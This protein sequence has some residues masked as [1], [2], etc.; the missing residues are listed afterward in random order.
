MRR[1]L[2]ALGAL[3]V[4]AAG[5]KVVKAGTDAGVANAVGADASSATAAAG[6]A[7]DAG[8]RIAGD[9]AVDASAAATDA[10]AAPAVVPLP[11]PLPLPLPTASVP[12]AKLVGRVFARGSRKPV[13]DASISIDLGA[14]GEAES[15]HDGRFAFDVPCGRHQLRVQAPGFQPLAVERDACVDRA[16]LLVR[17]APQANASNYETLVR[18]Q[19]VHQD[20]S[21][22][23]D[24]LIHTAGTLGDPFRVIETLPGVTSV[25]WPAPIYAVRGSNPGNTGFFL[26][27]LRVPALFHFALGPSVINPY[28]FRDLDFFAGG[29]PA[30]YGRYVAGIVAARTRAAPDDDLH[31]SVDLRLYDAGAIV[32]APLPGQGSIA[33]AAR[34]SYTGTVI[35]YLSDAA[36]NLAYWDYQLRA[37]RSFG[38]VRLTLLAFGSS[39]SL[40]TRSDRVALRFH[41]V[42]LRAERALGRG[43]IAA[44]VG[45]GQDHSEAPIVNTVPITISAL[46]V[47]PRAAYTLPSQ[48]ADLELGFDGEIEHFDSV[49]MLD[50]LNALDLARRRTARL[51]AGYA[52]VVVRAGP[53]LVVTPELRLDSYAVSGVEKADLGPRLAARLAIDT[54]TWV[55]LSGGRF[56]QLPS[57]PLQVPGAE[58]F[59]LALYGLQS[60]WQG[61]LALGTTRFAG[62]DAS[63][64][65]Y[66]QRYVLTDVRDSVLSASVDPL[67]DDF[68]VQRDALSYGVELFIRRPPTERLHGWLSYTLSNNER[69]LGGGVIGPS[70]WDQ[71]QVVNLVLGYR[72]RSYTFGGRAH[73]NTGRP[74][75]VKGAGGEVFQRLPPFFQLDLRCD[76]RV[77]Y[78][79]FTL[80]VYAELVNATL[81]QQVFGLT[82]TTA[83][84]PPTENSFRIV[85]PSIGLHAE[86]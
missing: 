20:V 75:L 30:R 41:R 7:A 3:L 82:Q 70:D 22:Q 85:L 47:I 73:Y 58:N 67:T 25:A 80:D 48:R 26:D 28:F 15:A 1:R 16:P 21:V 14:G 45:L 34:Y 37:D 11:L 4:A 74:V 12:L 83:D 66:V 71:R 53:R 39:D 2:F 10:A 5:A 27:D 56:T 65:G 36:V 8:A 31:A 54:E 72:W 42:K 76:R 61:A 64:T 51:L 9:A 52:S 50:P 46:S 81:S 40:V 55:K 43:R 18:A 35:N 49:T 77:L 84:G 19:T 62:L 13:P 78:N 60:S 68:L 79:R 44:S 29:Y 24:E 17:L 69:A 38:P 63:I 6:A 59:G 57:L 23:G 86:F 32:T 33:V